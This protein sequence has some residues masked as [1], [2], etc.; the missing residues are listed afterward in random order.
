MSMKKT[1]LVKGLARKLEGRMK[2]AGVPPRFAED[3]AALTAQKDLE[4]QERRAA[5]AAVKLTPLACRLPADLVVRLRERAA[6]VD[7]GVNA[8]LAQALSHWLDRPADPATDL[9]A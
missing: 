9:A 5:T 6:D 4:R 2:T 1:D 3:S 7:G 8:V